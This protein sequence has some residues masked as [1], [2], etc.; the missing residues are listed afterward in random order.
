MSRVIESELYN[1]ILAY[2]IT[3]FIRYVIGDCLNNVQ[4]LGGKVVS[5]TTV[6]FN[7]NIKDME[8]KILNLPKQPS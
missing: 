1:P 5:V 4:L 3:A 2:G 6:G 7:T 8:S